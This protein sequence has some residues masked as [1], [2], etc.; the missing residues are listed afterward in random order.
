MQPSETPSFQPHLFI[1]AERDRPSSI[2]IFAMV[3]G[4]K[5]FKVP[6]LLDIDKESLEQQFALVKGTISQHFQQ[7]RGQT[8]FNGKITGYLYRPIAAEQYKFSVDGEFLG[9]VAG[10]N[11][12]SCT[13]RI[14]NKVINDPPVFF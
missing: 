5:L 12:P 8:L 2:C 11:E 14:G 13:L 7:S 10:F 1:L 9:K 6:L 3:G 4:V